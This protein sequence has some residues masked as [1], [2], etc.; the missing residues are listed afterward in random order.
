MSI[1]DE[2][3]F[4]HA[5]GDAAVTAAAHE[6]PQELTFY[7]GWFCP[8][9]QRSWISLEEKGIPYQYKEVNPYKKEASFLA[10]NPKGLVPAIEY[11]GKALY[12]SLIICEFLDDAYP[13]AK[14]LLPRDPYNKAYARIWIDF[15]NKS[16]IPT[17]MRLGMAQTDEKRDAARAEMYAT[18]RTYTAE[19]KG[20]YFLGEEFSLVDIAIVPW[21]TRDYILAEHRGYDRAAVS[22]EWKRYAELVEARESVVKTKSEKD[23]Y[24]DIVG[25]YL[26][27]EGQSEAAKAIRA[28]R[29]IP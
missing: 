19:A 13:A 5:T 20:P 29:V 16:F 6:A 25:R 17:F 24:A 12:E 28:G 8:F 18:L 22:A 14:P 1:S 15:I 9:V 4:P 27:G 2:N 3:I 7:A 11:Q 10:L 26:R 21:I 23:K